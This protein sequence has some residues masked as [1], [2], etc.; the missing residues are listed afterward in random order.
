MYETSHLYLYNIDPIF[1]T[2]VFVEM[3]VEFENSVAL[4]SLQ[5]MKLLG[6]DLGRRSTQMGKSV[7]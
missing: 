2:I 6:E 7:N 3:S 1:L 5:A 4:M